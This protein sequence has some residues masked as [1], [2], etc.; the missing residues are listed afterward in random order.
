L[1][2]ILDYSQAGNPIG[3]LPTLSAD[4]WYHKKTSVNPRP[5]DV[6]SFMSVVVPF[7]QHDYLAALESFPNSKPATV[8][9]LSEYTG[10]APIVLTS[11][12]GLNVA[13]TDSR[14]TLH[15]LTTLLKAEGKVLGAYDGRALGVDTGIAARI[16]P[17]SGGNDATMTAVNGVY[18]AMWNNYL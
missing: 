5:T 2:S 6:P 8:Q 13:D 16:D 18:T 17:L 15:F 14:G 7:A 10:I 11:W 1:S 3:L 12:E 4:A 9:T